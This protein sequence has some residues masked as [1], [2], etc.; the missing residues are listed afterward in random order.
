MFTDEQKAALFVRF[1]RH[2][3][4]PLQK[5]A[6][7]EWTGNC[8]DGRYGHF[9]IDGEPVKA[10][11]WI[12]EQLIGEIPD[13]LLIRHKCDNPKCVCPTHLTVGSHSDNTSD[14]IERGRNADRKGTKHPLARVRED[15]VQEIRRLCG[16]GMTQSDV[17]D[18]YRI[19]R[20]QIGKIIRRQNW[21]HI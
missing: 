20:S 19:S 13:G 21:S 11:R 2:V 14:M 1:M 17:A 12:Y 18:M 7:W 16:Q 5:G 10:H 15:E 4:V 9:S 8:P 6:C 3:R